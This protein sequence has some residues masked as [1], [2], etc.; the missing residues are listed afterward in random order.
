MKKWRSLQEKK[1]LDKHCL[2]F[3]TC[4]YYS[5]LFVQPIL[6][7]PS[8]H[9]T[10]ISW[11]GSG[12][13]SP[14]ILNGFHHISF[15]GVYGLFFAN[16][17]CQIQFR[18]FLLFFLELS[19]LPLFQFR[20]YYAKQ[21]LKGV[22]LSMLRRLQCSKSNCFLFRDFFLFPMTCFVCLSFYSDLGSSSLFIDFENVVIN[23]SS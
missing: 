22:F 7:G 4:P 9:T 6:W 15:H 18:F 10:H 11:F 8:L 13:I 12:M 16:L 21:Y 14:L 19:C 1:T 3:G 17:L 2:P 20:F 23:G 5:S